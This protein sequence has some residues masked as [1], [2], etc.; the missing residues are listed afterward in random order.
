MLKRLDDAGDDR[1]YAVIRGIGVAS[2]GRSA[3]LMAPRSE[4]QVAAMR[5]AW[6]AA[7]LDPTAPGAVGLVEA[8]GT[9]TVAGDATELASLT[10]VFGPRGRPAARTSVSAR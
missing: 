4:G 8:H 6:A 2:D 10:Q 3:S 9:A 7:G 5:Q 1:V